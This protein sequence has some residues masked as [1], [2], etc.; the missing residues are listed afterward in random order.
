MFTSNL[1]KSL[2]REF[3]T[4][5]TKQFMASIGGRKGGDDSPLRMISRRNYPSWS[6]AEKRDKDQDTLIEQSL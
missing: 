2:V 3:T 6:G 1:V 5:T 4:T